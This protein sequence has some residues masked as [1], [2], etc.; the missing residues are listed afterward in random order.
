[1]TLMVSIYIYRID[2]NIE[3]LISCSN[4]TCTWNIYFQATAG[5]S[6]KVLSSPSNK[7]WQVSVASTMPCTICS[8][9]IFKLLFVDAINW[10]V[11]DLFLLA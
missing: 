8:S 1:M 6:N 9:V 10:K 5:P 2:I 4:L 3:W 11:L 7:V